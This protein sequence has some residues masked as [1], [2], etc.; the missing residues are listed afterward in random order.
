[1]KQRRFGKRQKLTKGMPSAVLL[2]IV[3][4]AALF[5]LAGMLV[6][7]TVVKKQEKKFEPPKA[8]ERPK[9]KLKKPKV[10]IKKTSKPKPTTRIVTK[11]SRASM[12]DI[13]LPE[14]SGMGEGL[15]SDLGGFDMM[16]DLGEV[17]VFG[18]GQSIGNDLVGT[19]YELKRDRQGQPRAMDMRT[20]MSKVAK[21]VRSGWDPAKLGRYYRS[22]NK[23][24]ATCFMVP[25]V[26]SSVAPKAFGEDTL[27]YFFL[28]HYKGKLVCPAS[29]TNGITFRFWGQA[30]DILLVR[31][32]G[33]MV[34]NATWPSISS[35]INS[36]WQSSSADSRKYYLGNN[37][38]VVGDWIT[39]KPGDSLD[40]EVLLGE[41][42]GGWFCCMLVVEVEGV[43][44]RQNKQNGPILPMFKTAEPSHDLIDAIYKDLVPGE[45]SVT[46]GP[47]FC[48]YD[49][50]GK[51][52]AAKEPEKTEPAMPADFGE[53]EMRIWI[54]PDGKE[55]DA[56]FTAMIGGKV[57]LEDSHGRQR[58][59]PLARFSGEDRK[60]IELAQPPKFNI[61]FSK[62]SSLFIGKMSPFS[63]SIPPKMLD[64]VFGAKLKQTSTGEYNHELT[65]E[66]FAI[67]AEN[68]GDRFVL[69]DRRESRFTPTVEN[70]RS[71]EFYGKTVR[72]TSYAFYGDFKGMKYASYLVVVTDSR[73]KIIAHQTP[74][75]WLFENLENLRNLPVG[76]Y[77]DETCIRTYPSRPITNLY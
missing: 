58:K 18:S 12:P 64:Y 43:E 63:P 41:R 1:M 8:V 61:D 28:A 6:V 44:Y 65:V 5:L 73:G 20:F 45:A 62:K 77:M 69:L 14:M 4:H 2:S 71:H 56:R 47:V 15:G 19:F 52:V 11:V 7:F 3:I 30:D 16:P 74:K 46:N 48:D 21:F 68:F 25:P 37:R 50:S 33:K 27:G 42:G 35:Q 70:K 36:P 60:F 67:G 53:H 24:Y 49:T 17:T 38:S 40:M 72:L 51:T 29:H 75:K 54:G 32:D 59:V 55:L 57:I 13:Q 66:F 22:P 10:K 26:F 39:L 34:L 23:L 31:V 9:M 76:C